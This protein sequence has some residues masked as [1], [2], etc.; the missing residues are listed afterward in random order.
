MAQL[1]G[2]RSAEGSSSYY[3]QGHPLIPPTSTTASQNVSIGP[4]V[5][6]QRSSLDSIFVP[7]T[8]LGAP[9][10]LESMAWNKEKHEKEKLAGDF[11][12]NNNLSFNAARYL[13]YNFNF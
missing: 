1:V 11:F 7:H 6:N 3:G 12:F 13:R 2:T 4:L 8:I 10:L 9:P 5:C